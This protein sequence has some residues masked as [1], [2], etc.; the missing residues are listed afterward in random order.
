MDKCRHHS[1]NSFLKLLNEFIY[2]CLYEVNEMLRCGFA[3]TLKIRVRL[4]QDTKCI[5]RVCLSSSHYVLSRFQLLCN[6][7]EEK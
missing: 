6:R 7:D 3:L 5:Y 2:V 1:S 4:Y